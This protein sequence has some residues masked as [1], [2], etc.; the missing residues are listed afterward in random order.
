MPSPSSDAPVALPP[1]IAGLV[2]ATNSF[3]L[4][5]LIVTS[6]DD[7]LVNDQLM[8]LLRCGLADLLVLAF[9]FR[10]HNDLIIQLINLRN[11]RVI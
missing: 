9:Y 5:G 1:L 10:A 6:A 2:E 7:A 8:E 11:R 3:D 4:K